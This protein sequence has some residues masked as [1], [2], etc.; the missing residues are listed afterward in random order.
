MLGIKR[1]L[2]KIFAIEH[3]GLEKVFHLGRF[4]LSYTKKEKKNYISKISKQ[5]LNDWQPLKNISAGKRCFLLATGPSVSTQN[6]KRLAGEDC[7]SISNFFLHEDIHIIKPK[8]HFFAEY[9]SPLILEN[10][11][12]WLRLADEKLP[13]ETNIVLGLRDREKVKKYKL[14]PNRK[15]YYLSVGSKELRLDPT[16]LVIGPQN[17]VIMMFP[18]IDHLGY[19][20][21]NLIGCDMNRFADFGKQR[22]NFY[23]VDP[24]KNAT[25]AS[26]WED[27]IYEFGCELNAFKQFKSINDYFTTKNIKVYNI[28]PESWLTFIEKRDFNSL[29]L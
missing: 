15:V 11:I 24:R 5:I 10:F 29:N 9:H 28:S 14:F 13:F 8:L 18:V 7:F 27:V 23:S 22:R 2:T 6:L 21:I 1:R 3:K 17:G 20:E 26:S 12:E 25:D 4:T 19:N 16:Q